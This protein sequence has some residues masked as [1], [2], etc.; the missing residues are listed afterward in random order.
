MSI[1][2]EN[3][4]KLEER[5]KEL[6]S[7]KAENFELNRQILVVK[8]EKELLDG[9]NVITEKQKLEHSVNDLQSKNMMVEEELRRMTELCGQYSDPDY[10]IQ[11]FSHSDPLVLFHFLKM[12][13]SGILERRNKTN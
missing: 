11:R 10:L 6:D 3:K 9:S 13:H 2:M 8:E 4:N 1:E 7:L 12:L 5:E